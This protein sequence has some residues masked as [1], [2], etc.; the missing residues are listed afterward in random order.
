MTNQLINFYEEGP[1]NFALQNAISLL[2]IS[3]Q[4]QFQNVSS[5]IFNSNERSCNYARYNG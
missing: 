2:A 3:S 4:Y 1:A 5:P